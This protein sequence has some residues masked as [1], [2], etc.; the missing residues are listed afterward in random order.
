[1]NHHEF[2]GYAVLTELTAPITR[3]NQTPPQTVRS[4]DWEGVFETVAEAVNYARTWHDEGSVSIVRVVATVEPVASVVWPDR[5]AE[6]YES[7]EPQK[8]LFT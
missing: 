2:T 4:L 1:M 8:Q 5:D 6:P 7:C 3:C